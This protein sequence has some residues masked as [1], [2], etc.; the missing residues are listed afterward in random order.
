[1]APLRESRR[2]PSGSSPSSAC[3]A[4]G[5]A[6]SSWCAW[7]TGRTREQTPQ[8]LTNSLYAG[9]ERAARRA[10]GRLQP[11]GP[12]RARQPHAAPGRD[13][14][15][16][17][18]KHPGMERRDHAPRRGEP[19]PAE[20]RDRLR[21]QPAA[22]RRRHRSRQGRRPRDQRRDHR[23][24]PADHA[25]VARDHL[26]HRPRPRVP[27]DRP[28]ARRRP[29]HADRSRQHLRARRGQRRAGAAD[30]PGASGRGRGRAR[31]AALRPA[32]LDHDLGVAGRRLRSRQRDR[33]TCRRSPPRP[34]RPRR[35][36]AS[37]ASRASS[38]RPR[39]ASRSPSR[40]RS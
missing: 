3:A 40:S 38:S 36:S 15:P 20:P 4:R 29:A 39:A 30:R 19:R 24:D 13:R 12:R 35:A 18:R 31:A 33:A 10:R 34:C 32:A 11:G 14:R 37:P 21:A 17:L 9:A 23:P 28:G 27:G 8:A 2:S 26:L 6:L 7:P 22:V 16:G 5:I 1:M 25:G